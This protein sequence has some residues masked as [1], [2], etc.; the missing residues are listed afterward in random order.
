MWPPLSAIS[1]GKSGCHG[2]VHLNGLEHGYGQ[3]YIPTRPSLE[4]SGPCSK[5]Y[6]SACTYNIVSIISF[7]QI[8]H[9]HRLQALCGEGDPD[10]AITTR[11]LAMLSL[12]AV[13]RDI[14]PRYALYI[15]PHGSTDDS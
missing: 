1:V 2:N 7:L 15:G 10:V 5:L 6:F 8:S 12:M 3:L 4:H 13:F 11:K 14:A 9:L